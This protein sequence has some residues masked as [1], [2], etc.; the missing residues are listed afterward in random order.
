M[1]S[2][3]TLFTKIKL[4]LDKK[5]NSEI[6]K[7]SKKVEK[8]FTNTAQKIDSS[9][10][11]LAVGI[12][13]AFSV[14][15]IKGFIDSCMD[16][17][18]AQNNI[19]IKLKESIK[20]LGAY[21]GSVEKQ[22]TAFQR[23]EATVSKLE[24]T[25]IYGGEM[26]AA[27]EILAPKFSEESISK[28]LPNIGN[29]IAKN[30]GLQATESDFSSLGL[31]ISKALDGGMYKGL[32]T[33]GIRISE[34]EE[35]MLKS[36]NG[37]KRIDLFNKLVAK[38]IGDVNKEL[39]KTPA[40]Q[41][42]Q[43][44][45]AWENMK[46]V[47]GEKVYPVVA[48]LAKKFEGFIPKIQEKLEKVMDK[49]PELV[50]KVESS[51]KKLMSAYT[52]LNSK[53]DVK[54]I[55]A[56][57]GGLLGVA[58]AFKLVKAA[59][60]VITILTSPLMLAVGAIVGAGYLIWKNWDKVAPIF[61]KIKEKILGLLPSGDKVKGVFGSLLDA[62]GN[63]FSKIEAHLPQILEVVEPVITAVIDLISTAVKAMIKVFKAL[64]PV[65]NFLGKIALKIFSF[66][67]KAL[68]KIAPKIINAVTKIIEVA[69]NIGAAVIDFFVNLPDKIKNIWESIKEKLVSVGEF[70]SGL[71]SDA[72]ENIGKIGEFFSDIWE[73]IKNGFNILVKE[74]I[75]SAID[76]LGNKI[77][78]LVD[79]FD[80][81][82]K[83]VSDKK[84]LIFNKTQKVNIN[85][86]SFAISQTTE[87]ASSIVGNHYMAAQPEIAQSDKVVNNVINNINNDYSNTTTTS[88]NKEVSMAAKGNKT[89]IK[90]DHELDVDIK[91]P[92]TIDPVFYRTLKDVIDRTVK[93]VTQKEVRRQAIQFGITEG[94]F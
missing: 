66:I 46:Q 22:R 56:L 43:V 69:G 81:A 92:N 15:K 11:K 5:F 51:I 73:S 79:K 57:T 68:L 64:A 28:M 53:V 89:E 67:G 54:K 23:L 10:K 3:S 6:N 2:E 30:K 7:A 40:G 50:D 82:K 65:F 21:G 37:Q 94:D 26:L 58:K 87:K 34:A 70:F 76:F 44:V 93:N 83:W 18:A 32:Q 33:Y 16:A 77:K 4:T 86:D 42:K 85:P 47:M 24:K 27:A 48:K 35:K 88:N 75:I 52:K 72:G 62:L 84:D 60:S 17:Y 13:A 12:G 80:A 25:G 8:S 55:L 71:L 14:A 90:L 38:S 20:L 31:A 63:T 74:P 29:I 59:M 91:L 9:F 19:N 39:A 78:W 45:N 41:I 49:I 61:E 36:V 1:A